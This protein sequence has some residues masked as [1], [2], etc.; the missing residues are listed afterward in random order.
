MFAHRWLGYQGVACHE[1]HLENFG[2]QHPVFSTALAFY[3]YKWSSLSLTQVS[4]G[5]CI[6]IRGTELPKPI[7]NEQSRSNCSRN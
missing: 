4:D 5:P 2:L 6:R 1:L 3:G 7:E